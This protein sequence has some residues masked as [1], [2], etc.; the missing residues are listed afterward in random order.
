MITRAIA[1]AALAL[2]TLATPHAGAGQG[3]ACPPA[4]IHACVTAHRDHG[5]ITVPD[6]G[7]QPL[8]PHGQLGWRESARLAGTRVTF[9]VSCDHDG[10]LTVWDAR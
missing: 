6:D 7:I 3:P 5:R 1:T 2:A 9:P 4:G 8:C 10:R